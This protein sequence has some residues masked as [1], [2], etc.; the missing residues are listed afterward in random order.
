MQAKI[1]VKNAFFFIVYHS[2]WAGLPPLLVGLLRGTTGSASWARPL[3]MVS[4]IP[5]NI[6]LNPLLMLSNIPPS[7]WLT[8]TLGG[9]VRQLLHGLLHRTNAAKEPEPPQRKGQHYGGSRGNIAVCHNA[10]AA[11]PHKALHLR[12]QVAHRLL[13]TVGRGVDHGRVAQQ[14]VVTE[15]QMLGGLQCAEVVQ[16]AVLNGVQPLVGQMA[17]GVKE[18]VVI[19]IR[20]IPSAS[21]R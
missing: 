17:F 14:T 19:K 6:S 21:S 2:P 5:L 9:N 8:V 3:L 1:K 10:E 4:C 7:A 11:Q 16:R 12:D 20:L 13:H 15:A 18:F